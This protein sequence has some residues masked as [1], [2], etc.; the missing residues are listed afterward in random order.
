M[1][2]KRRCGAR[3]LAYINAPAL[4]SALDI[5]EMDK[6]LVDALFKDARGSI[7]LGG[8]PVKVYEQPVCTL[9]DSLPPADRRAVLF[10]DPDGGVMLL[11]AGGGIDFFDLDWARAHVVVDR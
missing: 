5:A 3:R 8:H 11:W 2:G 7:I 9:P 6:P 10:F 1:E 4:C